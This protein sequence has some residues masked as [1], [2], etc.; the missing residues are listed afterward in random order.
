MAQKPRRGSDTRE[1]ILLYTGRDFFLK[2][3]ILSLVGLQLV[4]HSTTRKEKNWKK[5]LG[6][7]ARPFRDTACIITS[8]CLTVLRLEL[9]VGLKDCVIVFNS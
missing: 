4:Q 7:P 1:G 9:K 8:L 2:T 5:N 3:L 6:R